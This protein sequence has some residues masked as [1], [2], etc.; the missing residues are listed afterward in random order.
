MRVYNADKHNYDLSVAYEDDEAIEC[1]DLE[2]FGEAEAVDDHRLPIRLLTDFKLFADSSRERSIDTLDL[3][4]FDW[5]SMDIA[6][7]GFVKPQFSTI[8][9]ALEHDAELSEAGF[10]SGTKVFIPLVHELWFPET[11]DDQ[12]SDAFLY[13]IA[14]L[15]HI[16]VPSGIWLRTPFAW[17]ILQMEPDY[18]L[19]SLSRLRAAQG[20]PPVALEDSHALRTTKRALRSRTA[21]FLGSRSSPSSQPSSGSVSSSPTRESSPADRTTA[22]PLPRVAGGSTEPCLTPIVDRI[23]A[24]LFVRDQ[25]VS[26]RSPSLGATDA[27]I[28]GVTTDMS[29]ILGLNVQEYSDVTWAEPLNSADEDCS[30][31]FRTRK[32]KADFFSSV[33]VDGVPYEIGDIVIVLPG[34]DAHADR[35]R[36]YASRPAQAKNS[37]ANSYWFV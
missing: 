17:Y 2:I 15:I 20:D 34:D 28:Q 37:L 24:G 25:L 22:K 11:D 26:G 31:I 1:A 14:Q 35:A 33:W 23:A 36:G 12:R 4:D 16:C 9:D 27:N 18:Y 3:A 6:V 30:I 10:P 13:K 8:D 21:H 7:V 5:E 32:C 19:S 29:D